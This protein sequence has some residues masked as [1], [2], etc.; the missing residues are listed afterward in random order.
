[1]RKTVL[2]TGAS[3]GMGE[4]LTFEYAGRDWNV[5]ATMRDPAKANPAFAGLDNVLVTRLD[6][7]D[8]ATIERA[9]EEA[10]DRFG[11]LDA[12]VNAAGYGQLGAVEEISPDQ[13]R[14]QFETN[15]V[16][17]V[18]VTQAVLPHMRERGSGHI[19]NVGSMGGHVS[20]PTMAVYCASKSAVQNLTEGLAKE[21][22]PLGIHVTLV[23][24]AG[25]DTSFGTSSKLPA[26]SI[27]AY[28][29]SYAEMIEFDKQAVRGDLVRSMAAVAGITGIDEPPLHLA[30]ATAG[31]EMVRGRFTELMDEYARWERVTVGTD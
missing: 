2:I 3:T 28:A 12:L 18:Q 25:F 19:L 15:V 9:V 27:P 14:D 29:P 13:L 6:V 26:T 7:T 21:V 17:L 11:A 20:L 24:P 16:G 8:T 10:I 31:L 5:V 4:A 22:G 1:M 23:E 30:V